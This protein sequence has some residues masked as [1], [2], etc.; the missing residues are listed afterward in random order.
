MRPVPPVWQTLQT[1]TK[2]GQTSYHVR[3]PPS[4]FGYRHRISACQTCWT[5][6]SSNAGGHQRYVHDTA[7]FSVIIDWFTMLFS[8]GSLLRA[9]FS[10][11]C[12]FLRGVATVDWNGFLSD[13]AFTLISFLWCSALVY[14]IRLRLASQNHSLRLPCLFIS[15]KSF[16]EYSTDQY[17][18]RAMQAR[19]CNYFCRVDGNAIRFVHVSQAATDSEARRT[20]WYRSY[21]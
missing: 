1:V 6:R 11:L 13:P 15:S 10:E 17:L 19:G 4:L 9:L 18:A 8:L 5:D 12:T 21:V 20:R 2:F 7:Y 14:S 16:L 3:N